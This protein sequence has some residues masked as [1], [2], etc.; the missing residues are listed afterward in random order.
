MTIDIDSANEFGM[1][2]GSQQVE[3]GKLP[4]T[5]ECR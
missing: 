1:K 3:E 4:R 2:S 5:E